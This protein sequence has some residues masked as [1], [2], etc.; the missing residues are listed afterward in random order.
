MLRKKIIIQNGIKHITLSE[1]EYKKIYEKECDSQFHPCD[2]FHI[3][4]CMCKDAC[5]CHWKKLDNGS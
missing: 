1:K 2:H 3:D 4:K 5:S